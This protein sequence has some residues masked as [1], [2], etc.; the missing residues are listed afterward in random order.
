M[1]KVVDNIKTHIKETGWKRRFIRL[2]Y[3]HAASSCA[4]GNERL[5]FHEVQG[6]S[7]LPDKPLASHD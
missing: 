2:G 4:C 7:H 5:G 6:I 1:H 3:G